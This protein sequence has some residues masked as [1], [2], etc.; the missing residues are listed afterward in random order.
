[1]PPKI[2]SNTKRLTCIVCPLSC[3]IDTEY[4]PKRIKSISGHQCK[5][6]KVYA[7]DELFAPTRIL[8]TTVKVDGGVLP[9]VSVKTNKPVPKEKLFSILDEIM[10][11]TLDA[12]VKLGDII[13]KNV[14]NTK[15]N[16][17]ATK[18]VE[19]I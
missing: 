12:P 15:A 10:Q 17:V 16:I 8:T 6:G 9:L 2:K 18:T 11:L 1:M 7:E 4:T 3:I 5:K 19:R 13:I 14:Q